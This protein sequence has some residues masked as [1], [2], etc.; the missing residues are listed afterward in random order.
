M[1]PDCRT[2]VDQV[3]STEETNTRIKHGINCRMGPTRPPWTWTRRERKV[4][5]DH[6]RKQTR[7]QGTAP[8]HSIISIISIVDVGQ[9][10]TGNPQ[11]RHATRHQTTCRASANLLARGAGPTQSRF[12][13]FL[14][15]ARQRQRRGG[16]VGENPTDAVD[17]Y[18]TDPIQVYR[19]KWR[20]FKRV[21][22]VITTSSEMSC[23]KG[24]PKKESI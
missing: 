24:K 2:P 1:C 21:N 22:K 7:F 23:N 12:P 18:S 5:A 17:V 20:R 8:I 3:A 15:S 19:R 13:L 6:P 9:N 16:W 14:S 4:N 10:K 11:T